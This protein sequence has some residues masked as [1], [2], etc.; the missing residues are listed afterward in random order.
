MIT[1]LLIGS[2]LLRLSDGT[3]QAFARDPEVIETVTS[4][5][6]GEVPMCPAP[7]DLKNMLTALNHRED[8]L[9]ER[10]TALRDRMHALDIAEEHVT[11][12]LAQLESAEQS[13][14]ETIALA[15]TAAETD[16]DRLTRVY[17]TMKPKQAAALFEEMD[18]NFAAGFL[19]RMRPDAAA[20]ILAGLTPE[21]AHLFSV[22]LAGRNAN[23]PRQ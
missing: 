18:P 17:E 13:L 16:L 11:E 19:G 2:A 14:R 8:G 23:V 12:K 5:S 3:G 9:V 7:D 4:N 15:D 6:S 20:A 10:E 21:A 1:V 22:V